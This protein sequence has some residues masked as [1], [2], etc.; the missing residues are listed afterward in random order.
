MRCTKL[1]DNFAVDFSASINL[2]ELSN[3][4]QEIVYTLLKVLHFVLQDLILAWVILLV[5]KN[6]LH[7]ILI[8]LALISSSI[9]S[10]L[11]EDM[12]SLGWQPKILP[13]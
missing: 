12:F 1:Y 6:S 3:Y 8:L 9:T 11:P 5:F 4:W 10:S 2:N 7:S 13:I